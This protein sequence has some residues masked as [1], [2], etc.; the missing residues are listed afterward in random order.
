MEAL[1]S[2]LPLGIAAGLVLGKPLGILLAVFACVSLGIAK[3]P[4]EAS[5]T[6]VVGVGC[7][8]GIGFT[9]SLFI[10]TLAFNTP[11]QIDAVRLGVI[12]GSVVST[13]LGLAI[14]WLGSRKSAL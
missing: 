12:A 7:L 6:H 11:A 14:L 4:E 1:T 8:A 5:W 13:I 2:S 3:L 10:G 9:M